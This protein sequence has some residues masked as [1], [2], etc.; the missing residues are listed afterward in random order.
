M[1]TTL[2]AA[3]LFWVAGSAQTIH[4]VPATQTSAASGLEMYRTYCASCHGTE[5]KGNGPA[6]SALRNRPT[7]LTELARRNSGRFPEMK[8]FNAITGDATVAAHG[9]R[10]MPVW[11]RV[12]LRINDSDASKAKLRIRNLTKYIASIQA[13]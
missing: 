4:K 3:I 8:V 5:G 11:G 10:D 13:K 9:S 7:D 6:S 1:K 2:L 12:F